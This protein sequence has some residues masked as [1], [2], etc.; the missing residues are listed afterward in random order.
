MSGARRFIFAGGGTGGHLYPGLAI[1]EELRARFGPE[2]EAVF[3]C[4]DRPID[5]QILSTADGVGVPFVVNPAKPL[6]LRPRGLIRFLRNW[7]RA[8]REGREVIARGRG[9]PGGAGATEVIAM[10]G[11]VAAP[12]VQAARAEGCRVTL[13]NLD[14]EPGKANRLMA[15]RVH[16][17]FSTFPVEAGY[18][19][20]WVRVPPVVRRAARLTITPD[21]ARGRLGMDPSR[22]TLMI[23]GGSQG[24]E[25]INRLMLAMLEAHPAAFAGWQV[26]HQTGRPDQAEIESAY[27]RA[28][29][30]ARVS[31]FV[32]EMGLWWRAADLCI[33]RSGAGN[34]AEAWANAVP[35]VFMPYP[36]HRD[37]HQRLNAL[38]LVKAGGARLLDDRI[39]P[40]ANLAEHGAALVGL[41]SDASE[42]D[43]YRAALL[44]LGPADGAARIAEALGGD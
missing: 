38:P 26:L 24:A 10:G 15:R 41:L 12:L 9:R 22:P 8:V 25:S 1:W 13:V 28:G 27:A 6:S 39:E 19:R 34:V 3:V 5:A 32:A 43:R 17:A 7:G 42:R 36:Y 30:D 33:G 4:S 18:A 20:N 37:Q 29:V 35:A 14:A 2:A 23:T 40:Q 31:R 21:E 11:F 44:K 16:Q